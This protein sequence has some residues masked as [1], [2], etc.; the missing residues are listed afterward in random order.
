MGTLMDWLENGGHTRKRKLIL[1]KPKKDGKIKDVLN[2]SSE[3]NL[4]S[5]HG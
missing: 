5:T 4:T 3:I 2:M 1:E